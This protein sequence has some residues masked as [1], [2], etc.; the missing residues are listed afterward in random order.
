MSLNTEILKRVQLKVNKSFYVLGTISYP[1]TR[2]RSDPIK[3][4]P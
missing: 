1:F 2:R 3:L 4:V